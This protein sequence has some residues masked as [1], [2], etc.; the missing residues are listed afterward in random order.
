MYVGVIWRAC[1]S[2]P[3]LYNVQNVLFGEP[4]VSWSDWRKTKKEVHRL[5]TEST[6]WPWYWTSRGSKFEIAL[7]QKLEG[8]SIWN[9]R[10]TSQA[11]ASMTLTFVQPWWG[12][13]GTLTYFHCTMYLLLQIS[14]FRIRSRKCE[15][16]RLSNNTPLIRKELLHIL[17]L[18]IA[19]QQPSIIHHACVFVSWR[20][21]SFSL[22][23]SYRCIMQI[24]QQYNS[25]LIKKRV[26]WRLGLNESPDPWQMVS[27][28]TW[29]GAEACC[30]TREHL[31]HWP[32]C[33]VMQ[34][35]WM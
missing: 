2:I 11:F 6:M 30:K 21:L 26:D 16:W 35:I 18:D 34:H 32:C 13:W 19:I 17:Y 20:L 23:T 4:K 3:C 7:S 27:S 10:D 1:L 22:H 12:R 31:R 9:K 24:R 14:C 25:M 28:V 5:Y 29:G 8:R 33:D 15:W